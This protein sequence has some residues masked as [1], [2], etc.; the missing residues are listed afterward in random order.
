V[1]MVIAESSAVC[2]HYLHNKI[3]EGEMQLRDSLNVLG[4]GI[5]YR[6]Y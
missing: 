3:A 6:V 2:L 5:L 1:G 4:F